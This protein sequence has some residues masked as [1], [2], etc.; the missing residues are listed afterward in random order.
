MNQLK[1]YRAKLNLSQKQLAD[2]LGIGVST[3]RNK[4]CGHREFTVS[5]AK[6]I[7]LVFNQKFEEI[8]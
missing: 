7:M 6:K 4:E 8:F 3:Y 5:E 2:T 1:M